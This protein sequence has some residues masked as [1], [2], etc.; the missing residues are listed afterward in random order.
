MIHLNSTQKYPAEWINV[1]AIEQVIYLE[2]EE[3]IHI[4]FS[5]GKLDTYT[6]ERAQMLL[7]EL[8]KCPGLLS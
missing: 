2:N 1:A 5:S 4:R 8:A 6:G 7:A 3:T